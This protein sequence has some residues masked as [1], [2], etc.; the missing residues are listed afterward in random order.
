MPISSD[1]IVSRLKSILYGDKIWH[2][3]FPEIEN[4]CSLESYYQKLDMREEKKIMHKVSKYKMHDHEMLIAHLVYL[5]HY[6]H[7]YGTLNH[8][9]I[10]DVL[11]MYNSFL[12]GMV[13]SL[14][15][16]TLLVVTSDHGVE[17]TGGHGGGRTKQLAGFLFFC[18]KDLYGNRN[19]FNNY[20]NNNDV[21]ND[22]G[23]RNV[24]NKN[25]N[26]KNLNN[27]INKN[28]NKD[29]V[30]NINES[31]KDNVN[32]NIKNRI[33]EKIIHKEYAHYFQMDDKWISSISSTAKKEETFDKS[34]SFSCIHKD[35]IMPTICHLLGKD[36][37]FHSTG[38]FLYELTNKI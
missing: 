9:D 31:N 19:D 38:T 25:G 17:N 11:R 15:D 2:D 32:N 36:V 12:E 18:G 21:K 30:N 8:K 22:N 37:T 5:D 10:K 14:D 7:R 3:L 33:C 23:N 24:G 6:G 35:D 16:D 26:N 27:N 1:N 29:N 20:N 34:P 28:N 4:D 13:K